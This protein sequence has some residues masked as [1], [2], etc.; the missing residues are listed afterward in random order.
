MPRRST[1]K[2][3]QEARYWS[4]AGVVNWETTV[5]RGRQAW[6]AFVPDVGRLLAVRTGILDEEYMTD[7]REFTGWVVN[8]KN[9]EEVGVFDTARHA[10]D[11]L[12]KLAM[13]R[14]GKIGQAK[15]AA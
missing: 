6:T 9:R 15:A 5:V 1:A 10:M 14:L 11:E 4:S 2:P 8:G 13:V 12:Q 7:C 3:A